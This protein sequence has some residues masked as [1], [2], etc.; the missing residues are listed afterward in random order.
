LEK[1][2][3]QVRPVSKGDGG[4]REGVGAGGRDGPNNV[5]TYE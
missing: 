2:T 5:R 4:E 1:R 3:E